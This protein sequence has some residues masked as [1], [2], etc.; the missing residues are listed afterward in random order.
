MVGWESRQEGW[1]IDTDGNMPTFMDAY[2]I[3]SVS[4]DIAKSA[5]LALPDHLPLLDDSLQLRSQNDAISRLLCLTAIGAASYGFDK[6]KALA[7]LSQEK[8]KDMLTRGEI[9]FLREELGSPQVFQAQIEGMWALAWA[10]SFVPSLGFWQDCDSRFVTLLPNLK[11]SQSGDQWRR[12]GRYRKTEDVI[13]ACDLAYCLHW[14]V[15]QAEID[16]KP[17]PARLK[18][19]VIVERRRALEWL[20]SNNAWDAISLDT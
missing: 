16:G 9:A 20:L 4:K 7:W 17:T 18:P 5:G 6:E 2:A 8:L 14:T 10:L 3:R 13:A 19:Y 15:R 12:K 11:I 1:P